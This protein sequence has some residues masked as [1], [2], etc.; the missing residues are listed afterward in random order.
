ML[1]IAVYF[2]YQRALS[3]ELRGGMW[4]IGLI[5]FGAGGA[6]LITDKPKTNDNE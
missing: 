1:L 4:G 2:G 6:Y 3:A 5:V